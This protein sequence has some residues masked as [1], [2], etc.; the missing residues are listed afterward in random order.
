[1]EEKNNLNQLDLYEKILDRSDK[2]IN[3]IHS[4]YKL[5]AYLVTICATVIIGLGA[6]IFFSNM[7][8]AK[9]DATKRV[10]KLIESVNQDISNLKVEVR[11]EMNQSKDSIKTSFLKNII[12]VE[13]EVNK[14]INAEFDKENISL[15]V[16]NTASERIDNIADQLIENQ[17]KNKIRPEL[18]KTEENISELEF[19]L[20]EIA[21]MND[22]RKAF[23]KILIWA[24][25]ESHQ[26]NKQ[27]I[28]FR[29]RILNMDYNF[30]VFTFLALSG[31]FD[32]D[33]Y[34]MN[35]IIKTYESVTKENKKGLITE[36]WNSVKQNKSD[37][38]K[39]IIDVIENDENLSCVAA[40]SSIIINEY[41]LNFKPLEIEKFLEW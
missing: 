37:K 10:D 25:D 8:E 33:K 6:F 36:V 13:S 34:S 7:N 3:R 2:E 23:D 40:A 5:A 24:K 17:I 18:N 1:M 14:R 35:E 22:D 30:S 29:E 12:E 32:M 9:E 31:Y 41:K 26:F 27:A 11:N 38:L 20:T 21:V 19:R 39:F 16:N 28:V 4:M 15:L